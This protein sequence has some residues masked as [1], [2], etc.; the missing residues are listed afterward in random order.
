MTC[1]HKDSRLLCGE[2]NKNWAETNSD[3]TASK[4]LQ[5]KMYELKIFICVCACACACVCVYIKSCVT[6]WLM[7]QLAL[8]HITASTER[9]WF[10]LGDFFLSRFVFLLN[11]VLGGRLAGQMG[12]R[13]RGDEGD[14]DARCEI[15]KESTEI[16][17]KI[18]KRWHCEHLG[19]KQ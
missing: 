4:H 18:F 16:K 17:K 6:R 8:G 2:Q 19:L 12:A 13:G 7:L 10:C 9:V 1:F 11:F 3:K 14:W 15:H 5:V